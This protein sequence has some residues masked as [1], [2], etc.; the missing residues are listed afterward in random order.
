MSA[1]IF[2]S[3]DHGRGQV[4]KDQFGT[5]TSNAIVVCIVG[6]PKHVI[7]ERAPKVPRNRC[8]DGGIRLVTMTA[9][10]QQGNVKVTGMWVIGRQSMGL[11][12]HKGSRPPLQGGL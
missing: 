7:V 1:G 9:G 2:I 4:V 3:D 5:N 11:E 8:A 6:H 12:K 10:S